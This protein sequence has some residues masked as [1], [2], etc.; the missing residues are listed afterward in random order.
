ME[1]HTCHSVDR[2]EAE[3]LAVQDSADASCAG[4][5]RLT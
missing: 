2:N 5:E 1:R 4:G 3:V